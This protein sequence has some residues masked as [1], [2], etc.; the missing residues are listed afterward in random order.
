[1]SFIQTRERAS[2]RK[3]ISLS[4]EHGART[5]GGSYGWLAGLNQRIFIFIKNVVSGKE[6][7]RRK[8]RYQDSDRK[9]K[10]G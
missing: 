1:M 5:G 2:G 10:S 8:K 7:S 4:Q 9:K 3:C 6:K